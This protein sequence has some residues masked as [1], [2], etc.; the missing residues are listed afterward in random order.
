MMSDGFGKQLSELAEALALDD[1]DIIYVVRNGASR[2]MTAATLRELMQQ[3]VSFREQ[4]NSAGTFEQ[5]DGDDILMGVDTSDTTEGEEGT[6]KRLPASQVLPERII[7]PGASLGGPP[8]NQNPLA[9][10]NLLVRQG[11]TVVMRYNNGVEGE[12]G[13]IAEIPPHWQAFNLDIE[14]APHAAVAGTVRWASRYT[15]AV[16]GDSIAVGTP[17]GGGV[18]VEVSDSQQWQVISTR[19]LSAI[20]VPVAGTMIAFTV[21]RRGGQAEDTYAAACGIIRVVLTRAAV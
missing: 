3:G 8:T 6:Q 17:G 15:L 12:T 20:P 4:A 10:N 7:I 13:S 5:V 11:A 19:L 2:K 14:W 18:N 9:E 1:A 16:V 21:R